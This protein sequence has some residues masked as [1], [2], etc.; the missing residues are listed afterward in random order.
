MSLVSVRR[1][2][3]QIAD[4]VE[5]SYLPPYLLDD[6][7]ESLRESWFPQTPLSSF[8]AV[9][10]TETSDHQIEV[11]AEIP[12]FT[13]EELQV[14]LDS[15]HRTLTFS[16]RNVREQTKQEDGRRYSYEFDVRKT[17]QLPARVN[18]D[19]VKASLENGVLTIRMDKAQ[20][21]RGG[22]KINI[23]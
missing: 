16:G 3:N 6:M 21:Q 18:P 23:G 4:V 20:E 7:L 2:L 5:K 19:S 9:N 11:T 1:L 12:G 14:H 22:V 10:V 15:D 8:P 17:L 13:Q